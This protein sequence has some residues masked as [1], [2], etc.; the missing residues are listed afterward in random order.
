ME[1]EWVE[2]VDRSAWFVT[3][4]PVSDG[5]LSVNLLSAM[6]LPPLT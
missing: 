3:G 1:K 4:A 6:F 5:D 2:I